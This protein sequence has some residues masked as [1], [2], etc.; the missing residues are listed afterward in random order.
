M[1]TGVFF[2]LIVTTFGVFGI[3][4][5]AVAQSF[6]PPAELPPESF[7][8]SQY[9]DSKGCIYIRAGASGVVTWVPR[10]TRDRRQIC[11]FQP[12]FSGRS[13]TSSAVSASAVK[14]L[15]AEPDTLSPDTRVLPKH[16]FDLRQAQSPVKTPRGYRSAWTD[17]RLNPRRAEGTLRGREQ[18]N[19]IWTNTVPRR[20]VVQ[21]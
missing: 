17:G 16:L 1:K 4:T 15:E 3:G 21:K 20:L 9:A 19:K 7:T 6:Q 8:G 11:G 14:V 5:P 10:V 2:L 12:T 18:M 13:A